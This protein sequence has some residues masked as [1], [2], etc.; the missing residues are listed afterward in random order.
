[1][2]DDKFTVV[3]GAEDSLRAEIESLK[4]TL[5][6][7]AELGPQIAQIRKTHFDAYVAAGFSEAQA[8][9]LCKSIT[10]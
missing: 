4:W 8:L 6:V 9:E 7:M 1:M 10:L 2:Q 5:P 3:P